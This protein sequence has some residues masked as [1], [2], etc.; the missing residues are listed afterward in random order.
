[1]KALLFDTFGWPEVLQYRELP[2][3]AVP[4]GH[5]QLAMRAIGL[6]F[7]DLHRR[8]AEGLFECM[9]GRADHKTSGRCS[10]EVGVP[11]ALR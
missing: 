11:E 1:M 9:S 6:N 7:A 4:P 5:V 3:P 2:D 8:G 10:F